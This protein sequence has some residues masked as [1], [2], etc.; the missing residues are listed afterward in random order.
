M[1]FIFLLESNVRGLPSAPGVYAFKKGRDFL[2]V[3]KAV[4]IR[5]RV[6]NH[7]GQPVFKDN[8]FVPQT[9]KIGYIATGSEIEAL[10]LE[11]E[12][13]KKFQPKYNKIWRDDKSHYYVFITKEDFP[14]V[15][16]GHQLQTANCKLL[17]NAGPFIDGKALKQALRV[18]RK[19]FPFRACNKMPKKPCLYEELG[20]CPAPCGLKIKNS[21]FQK[22]YGRNIRNLVAVLRGR[23]TSV[24]KNLRKEMSRASQE[25]DFE[26]AKTLR[27]QIRALENVFGHS[28]I[29]GQAGGSFL[30]LQRILGLKNKI[31]RM[32]G[33]DISNIQG[34]QATGSMVVFEDGR[35]DKNEYRKFKIK[36]KNTPDDI[37]MLKEVLSRR[38]RH[39]EWPLPQIMLIDG[40]IGQLNIALKL[41]MKNEKLKNTKIASLAKRKNELFLENQPKPVLLKNLPQEVANLIL[42]VRNEAHRFAVAYHKVLRSRNLF[43]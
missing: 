24:V 28:R 25:R 9:E 37:A 3:G 39:E 27:D 36:F 33:Y 43:D 31:K 18:L 2:Y 7:F 8:V 13:I 1:G 15:F 6:K 40:G 34:K 23:K 16:A 17:A 10:L 32:E 30:R 19:V 11:A 5:E 26:K 12:L 29:L 4:N 35:P 14:R 21:K 22:E 20:L 38:L 42:A 41:K